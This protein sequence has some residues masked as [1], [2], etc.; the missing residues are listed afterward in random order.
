MKWFVGIALGSS[1]IAIPA[2][3]PVGD[4]PRRMLQHVAGE[5]ARISSAAPRAPGRERIASSRT[6]AGS[7]NHLVGAAEQWQRHCDA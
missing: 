1:L 6:N 4:R 2:A 7:L 3:A 5:L